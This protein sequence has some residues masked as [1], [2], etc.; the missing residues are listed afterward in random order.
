VAPR[1]V[2]LAFET[3]AGLL[4]SLWNTRLRGD[5]T[6]APVAQREWYREVLE[7]P[8][9]VRKLRLNARNSRNAK[10]R[11]GRLLNVIRAGA[12]VDPDVAALWNR[13]ETEFHANQRAVVETLHASKALRRGLSVDRATDVLWT[14]NH[15]DVWRLLV[16][17]RGWTPGQ[18]ERWFAETSRAQLLRDPG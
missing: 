16:A 10:S 18:Y 3:K 6:E 9:P 13:I 17:E 5:D 12:Q 11:V 4:R 1:T 8:D 14:L 7:E 2:S 15:P